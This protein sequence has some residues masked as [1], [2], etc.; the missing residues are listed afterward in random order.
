MQ[1]VILLDPNSSIEVDKKKDKSIH[2][3]LII[4]KK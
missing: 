4:S 2:S 3:S 1:A